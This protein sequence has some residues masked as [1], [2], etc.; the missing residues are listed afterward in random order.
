MAIILTMGMSQSLVAEAASTGNAPQGAFTAAPYGDGLIR[1]SGWAFDRDN[2]GATVTATFTVNGQIAGSQPAALRSPTLDVYGL[3]YK[4]FDTTLQ[5]QSAGDYSVC[6]S[7][8]DIGGGADA[9]VG[10]RSVT[11]PSHDPR[12]DI[13][14]TVTPGQAIVT[15]GWLFDESDL[16]KS[17]GLWVVDNGQIVANIQGNLPSPYL[18]PYGVPGQHAFW[19]GHSP[20]TPGPHDI[21]VYGINVG[22]GNHAWIKCQMVYIQNPPVGS[23]LYNWYPTSSAMGLSTYQLDQLLVGTTGVAATSQWPA[24]NSLFL[25]YLLPAFITSAQDGLVIYP[26]G[27]ASGRVEVH[28]TSRASNYTQGSLDVATPLAARP[29]GSQDQWAVGSFNGSGRPDL[30]FIQTDAGTASGKVEVHVLSAVSN[31]QTWVWHSTTAFPAPV[32]NDAVTFLVGDEYGRGDLTAII[33]EN[34]RSGVTEIHRMTKASSFQ[35][36]DLQTPTSLPLGSSSDWSYQ[37]GR[38]NDADTAPELW[39]IQLRSP[40]GGNIAVNVLDGKTRALMAHLTLPWAYG[41]REGFPMQQYERF[42]VSP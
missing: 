13:L 38:F 16:T 35:Q 32:N 4:G 25:P 17:L 29:Y 39:A 11:V 24:Y 41:G 22:W 42:F 15:V 8:N 30:W 12:G 18:Y 26:S 21:C 40:A 37:L 28:V 31:Y 19:A 34:S 23:Q 36:Y 2:F 3:P 10:C 14:V 27:T 20:A 6:L 1:V 9:A 33:H 5:V 7:L